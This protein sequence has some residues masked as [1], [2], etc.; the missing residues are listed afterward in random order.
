MREGTTLLICAA[1]DVGL[2]RSCNEDS[3]L[4]AD[5]AG[6]KIDIDRKGAV[7]AVAD[8]MGGH[9]GGDIASR[10]AVQELADCCRLEG[11]DAGTDKRALLQYLEKSIFSIHHH[12]ETYGRRHPE[13]EGLGTTLSVLVLADGRAVMAHVGDS[14]IYRLRGGRLE[15]MTSDHTLVGHFV[16]AGVMTAEEAHEHPLR[17]V[18]MQAVGHGIDDVFTRVEDLQP[19]DFF[20]LCSDGLHDIVPLGEIRE[21]LLSKIEH[22]H[23]CRHLV[24]KALQHGGNDNVT[25]VAIRVVG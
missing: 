20:L 18:M 19:Q 13:M 24:E 5:G 17:H 21:I 9:P 1:T 2:K 25:V 12:I 8:G 23:I 22:R 15:Q 4:V 7:F 11:E 16:E 3:Y 10:I 6:T 14:R